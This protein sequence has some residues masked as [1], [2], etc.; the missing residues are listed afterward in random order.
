MELVTYGDEISSPS[1]FFD[2]VFLRSDVI[3]T[4]LFCSE[5]EQVQ[6]LSNPLPRRLSDGRLQSA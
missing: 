2:A 5:C 3:L 4:I 6:G 1:I